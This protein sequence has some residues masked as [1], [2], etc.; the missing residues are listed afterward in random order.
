MFM[1]W[2]RGTGEIL[3]SGSTG[4]STALGGAR[5]GTIIAGHLQSAGRHVFFSPE[6]GTSY[7]QPRFHYST[8]LWV[9]AIL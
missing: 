4:Y 1:I 6:S 9:N 8:V 3:F 2:E 5:K 7:T